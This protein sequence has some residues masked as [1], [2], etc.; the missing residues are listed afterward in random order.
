MS[1]LDHEN[2][3][4]EGVLLVS[5]RTLATINE[6]NVMRRPILFIL[7]LACA[8]S[9]CESLSSIFANNSEQV[10]P[11]H[12]PPLYVPPL[13]I[14]TGGSD[15]NEFKV[16][17]AVEVK[18]DLLPKVVE[19]NSPTISSVGLGKRSRPAGRYLPLVLFPFD[20]WELTPDAEKM[21]QE[22]SDWL[23]TSLHG[24]LTIEG[25]TDAKGTKAYNHALG[26][27]RA[28]AV[29]KYLK[30][31]GIKPG[32]ME[33]ISFGELDP[34][35]QEE[36]NFCDDMNRRAFMFVA[37]RKLPPLL[38]SFQIPLTDLAQPLQEN[39]P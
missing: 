31:L 6:V 37:N 22:A 34:I 33:P 1:S 5:K 2:I 15:S 3:A 27:K 26:Y 36:E 24:E 10:A 20:S 28:Q 19:S 23:R 7:I 35:C 14:Q 39:T 21:L 11:L 4:A 13:Q 17:E 8:L 12:V 18:E 16:V 29:M 30:D 32:T 38:K 9:G 25:H